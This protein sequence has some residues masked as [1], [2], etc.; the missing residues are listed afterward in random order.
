MGLCHSRQKGSTGTALSHT[1]STRE[2]QQQQQEE[3]IQTHKRLKQKQ[4][5]YFITKHNLRILG[6]SPFFERQDNF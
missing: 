5:L 6:V 1:D 2:Q 3:E 4:N